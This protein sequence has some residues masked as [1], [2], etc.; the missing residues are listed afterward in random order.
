MFCF[1]HH[2]VEILLLDFFDMYIEGRRTWDWYSLTAVDQDVHL[3]VGTRKFPW[4]DMLTTLAGSESTHYKA[5][6]LSY[7]EI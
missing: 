5:S 6:M 3:I 4:L 2:Q 1:H 7:L